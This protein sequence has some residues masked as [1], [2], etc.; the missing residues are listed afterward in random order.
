MFS[1]ELI[2]LEE[3]LL[4]LEEELDETLTSKR[5]PKEM[6]KLAKNPERTDSK[7]KLPEAITFKIAWTWAI[8][9]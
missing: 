8:K 2:E 7:L 5:L 4:E 6:V 1:D 3:E 9:F